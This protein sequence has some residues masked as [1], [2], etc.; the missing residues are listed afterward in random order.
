M[1]VEQL[2]FKTYCTKY[3]YKDVLMSRVSKDCLTTAHKE[4]RHNNKVKI[5]EYSAALLNYLFDRVETSI[6]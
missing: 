3:L 2:P 1:C 6:S 5:I 4:G